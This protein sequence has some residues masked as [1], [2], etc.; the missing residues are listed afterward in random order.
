MSLYITLGAFPSSCQKPSRLFGNRRNEEKNW[1]G[2]SNTCSQ[3]EM[4]A[5]PRGTGVPGN[6]AQTVKCM[7]RIKCSPH[8]A[9][10]PHSVHSFGRTSW[11]T[12]HACLWIY[13]GPQVIVGIRQ[14][15]FAKKRGGG[16]EAVM[17]RSFRHIIDSHSSGFPSSFDLRF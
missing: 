9:L 6:L 14:L 8:V 16:R 12:L 10:L 17:R 11:G 13:R 3:G 4:I 1:A 7:Q 5:G 2:S 15:Y